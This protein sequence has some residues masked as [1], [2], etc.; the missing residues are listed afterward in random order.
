M[1]AF[2]FKGEA[3]AKFYA[4]VTGSARRWNIAK[5]RNRKIRNTGNRKFTGSIKA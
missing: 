4:L 3:A 2:V 1:A 5:H